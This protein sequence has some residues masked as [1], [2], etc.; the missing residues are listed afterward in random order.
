MRAALETIELIEKYLL[1]DLSSADK[2]AF[3]IELSTDPNLQSQVNLQEGV[4]DGIKRI[5]LK[6]SA[7]AARKMYQLRKWG[8]RISIL[9]LLLL[10]TASFFY[11]GDKDC[12]PCEGSSPIV[13]V[14][15]DS[16]DESKCCPKEYQ[17]PME[18]DEV[19]DT[20]DAASEDS[21]HSLED[22]ADIL[23]DSIFYESIEKVIEDVDPMIDDN[24]DDVQIIIEEADHINDRNGA[25]SS[26]ISNSL[27]T[28]VIAKNVEV[29][30]SFPGGEGK[31]FNWL[32]KNVNYPQS[33][34]D[35]KEGGV[36]QVQ[37]N[38][39]ASGKLKNIKIIKSISPAL[40]KEAIRLVNAMPKW[41][42]ALID[43]KPIEV[44]YVMPL[45]FKLPDVL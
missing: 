41:N 25:N 23:G 21:G 12:I 29:E 43:G 44:K 8:M 4:V 40:D 13:E 37:F 35:N 33:A 26:A 34:L 24:L 7:V 36:V 32:S 22:G 6:T 19:C 14:E 15:R 27:L 31:M 17:A 28:S 10:G 1:N 18:M 11:F 9:L 38:V 16:F 5:G 30:A 45:S 3:E 39:S 42:P 2:V 20:T